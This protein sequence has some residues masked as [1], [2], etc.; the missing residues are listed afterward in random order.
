MWDL[1]VNDVVRMQQHGTKGTR[2]DHRQREIE[3]CRSATR[4]RCQH[5]YEHIHN[6]ERFRLLEHNI[7]PPLGGG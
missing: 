2:E 5:G 6:V 7:I 4:S 1:F 3:G